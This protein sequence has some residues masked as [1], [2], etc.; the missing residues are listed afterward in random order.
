MLFFDNE[1]SGDKLLQSERMAYT[2]E[3]ASRRPPAGNHWKEIL[4][5]IFI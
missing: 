1:T 2:N 4:E 5:R 3:A